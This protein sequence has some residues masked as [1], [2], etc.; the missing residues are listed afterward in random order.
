MAI[1][2]III[3]LG[4]VQASDT[5]EDGRDQLVLVTKLRSRN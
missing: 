1:I 3:Q 5:A 4:V 2:R